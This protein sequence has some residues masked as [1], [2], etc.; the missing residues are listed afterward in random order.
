MLVLY[1][2][3]VAPAHRVAAAHWA[4]SNP[5][6]AS[7][8]HCI[9]AQKTEDFNP[10]RDLDHASKTAYSNSEI[11]LGATTLPSH[12]ENITQSLKL[13]FSCALAVTQAFPTSQII[14]LSPW[15]YI[16]LPSLA[17]TSHSA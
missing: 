11:L 7:F 8:L 3:E 1:T 10:L 9:G 14:F 16:S 15:N 6:D 4:C 2:T 5:R 17:P 13:I 12:Y